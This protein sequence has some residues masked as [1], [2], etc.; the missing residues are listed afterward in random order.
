MNSKE[1]NGILQEITPLGEHDFMFVADRHKT[2]YDF[3]LHKH[4]LFELNFIENARG[5]RRIVGDSDEL[6]DDIDLVLISSPQLEH[7]WAQGECTS[8]DIH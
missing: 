6:T 4:D 1:D 5:C 3:P 2:G 8:K 7:Q